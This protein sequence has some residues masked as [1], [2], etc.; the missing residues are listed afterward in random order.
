MTLNG[1]N[2]EQI[3]LSIQDEGHYNR[4]KAI[5]VNRNFG[6]FIKLSTYLEW[7]WPVNKEAARIYNQYFK[8]CF[9]IWTSMMTSLGMSKSFVGPVPMRSYQF[10]S[11]IFEPFPFLV[12]DPTDSTS[13]FK[14]IFKTFDITSFDKWYTI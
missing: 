9:F 6:W 7:F 14:P 11:V 3:Y 12:F 8:I 13:Q 10:K 5:C 4:K 1:K 2:L